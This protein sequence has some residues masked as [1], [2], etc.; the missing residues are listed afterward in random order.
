V[1]ILS[2]GEFHTVAERVF[3]QSGTDW[4]S[5]QV[6]SHT[7]GTER[8]D[9][10][11]QPCRYPASSSAGRPQA[12]AGGDR[13]G[14]GPQGNSVAKSQSGARRSG[15]NSNRNATDADR[16]EDRW[17]LYPERSSSSPRSLNHDVQGDSG[18][19][20]SQLGDQTGSVV[21]GPPGPLLQPG[22]TR[23]TQSAYGRGK[24]NEIVTELSSHISPGQVSHLCHHERERMF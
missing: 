8:M 3:H 15:S 4:R 23:H 20:N 22:C 10:H 16:G 9:R 2:T 1:H 12:R 14:T 18:D 24:F 13:C 5:A 17:R 6:D 11:V 19:L 7:G 21:F